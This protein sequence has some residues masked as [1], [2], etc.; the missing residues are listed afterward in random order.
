MKE[1]KRFGIV[2]VCFLLIVIIFSVISMSHY[3]DSHFIGQGPQLY[4]IPGRLYAETVDY[5][6]I[7]EDVYGRQW[8]VSGYIFNSGDSLLFEIDDNGT[9]ED[10]EDD[11]LVDI[12][13]QKVSVIPEKNS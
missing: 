7:V 12:Y 11:R 5:N 10:K 3:T 4:Y 13:L 9:P 1:N 2:A 8:E 6:H